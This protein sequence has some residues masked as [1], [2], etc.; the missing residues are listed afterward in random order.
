MCHVAHHALM[1]PEERSQVARINAYKSWAATRSRSA[2]T[3]AGRRAA[4]QRFTA[5][6]RELL[7]PD[8]TEK[9]VAQSAEA[10]RSAWYRELALRSAKARRNR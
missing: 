4:D 7:G 10:L 8:A 1:D 3:A 9:Q 6:A 2:R 5:Q